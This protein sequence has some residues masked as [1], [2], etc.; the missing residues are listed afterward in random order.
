MASIRV[1]A[2]ERMERNVGGYV[3]SSASLPL[4]Y[5][6][7]IAIVSLVGDCGHVAGGR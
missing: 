1:D 2:V 6:P 3:S 7:A 5:V 4:L